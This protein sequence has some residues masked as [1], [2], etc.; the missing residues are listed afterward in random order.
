LL[1]SY[2]LFSNS[3]LKISGVHRRLSHELKN[4]VV[5]P[6]L[7]FIENYR[8]TNRVRCAVM[9]GVSKRMQTILSDLERYR[10]SMQKHK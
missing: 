4:K 8:E 6:Y 7:M 10:E 3:L 1:N 2:Q 9:Q 5:D